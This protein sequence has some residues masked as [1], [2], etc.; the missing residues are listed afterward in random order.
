MTAPAQQTLLAFAALALF[1]LPVVPASAQINDIVCMVGTETRNPVM[2]EAAMYIGTGPLP[3]GWMIS[4][5]QWQCR[6]VM[7]TCATDWAVSA[8][9]GPP[10]I[11]WIV[12]QW[13]GI[14][15]RR[16]TVS[17]FDFFTMQPVPPPPTL[18]VKEFTVEPADRAEIVGGLNTPAPFG[19]PI[20]ITFRLYA[21]LRPIGDF[22]AGLAQERI[23]NQ[24]LLSPPLPTESLPDWPDWGPYPE[25]IPT[26]FH[27]GSYIHDEKWHIGSWPW[28]SEI[29]VGA[30][31][32]KYTQ[33]LRLRWRYP[34]CEEEKTIDLGSFALQR[35]KVSATHWKYTLQ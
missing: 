7:G 10:S 21:G 33:H 32:I 19:S 18:V 23:T 13:P 1:E 2:G 27:L 22:S 8:G 3:N 34:S 28:W 11:F 25:P 6:V 20:V 5:W 31:Y 30:P 15:E 14:A 24:W 35:V 16:Q 12:E 9:Y 4:Q 29:P 17:Y 26:F